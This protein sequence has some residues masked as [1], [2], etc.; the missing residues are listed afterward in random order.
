MKKRLPTP[1]K[2]MIV[3]DHKIII[4]SLSLLLNQEESVEVVG[5]ALNVE[6][7][8]EVFVAQRPDVVLMDIRIPNGIEGIETMELLLENYPHTRFLMLTGHSEIGLIGEALEKGA[9]G[10]ASKNIDQ[11]DLIQGIQKVAKGERFLDPEI[12]DLVIKDY[13]P[14]RSQSHFKGKKKPSHFIITKRER[15]VLKH[16]AMGETTKAI[17]KVLFIST[18]TVDTHRKNLLEKCGVKNTAELIRFAAENGLL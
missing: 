1:I 11:D 10:Y 9:T 7:A 8:L 14:K 13:L 6:T 4:D 18:N 16:I 17:A 2:V 15:E 5:Y 12:L 3:D